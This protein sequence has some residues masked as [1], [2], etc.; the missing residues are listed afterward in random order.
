MEADDDFFAQMAMDEAENEDQEPEEED[1]WDPP[2]API[3]STSRVVEPLPVVE[4]DGVGK[5]RGE[6][7]MG[8]REGKRRLMLE[9]EE[10]FGHEEEDVEMGGEYAAARWEGRQLMAATTDPVLNQ[11]QATA[12]VPPQAAGRSYT[13]RFGNLSSVNLTLKPGYVEAAPIAATTFDGRTFIIK[14]RKR[15]D[16]FEES[17]DE[18]VRSVWVLE[19]ET[20]ADGQRRR[21]TRR[22]CPSSV[23][24]CSRCRTTTW[25]TRSRR[26]QRSRRSRTRR[27]RESSRQSLSLLVLTTDL[28]TVRMQHSLTILRSDWTARSGRIDIGQRSSPTC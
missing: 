2:S 11:R 23:T 4:V 7:G 6:N 9:P 8:V 3:A 5:D 13:S 1:P 25:S 18:V 20:R 26:M 24:R 19:G 14:R 17:A 22:R 16:G 10:G 27:T 28:R 15:V 21:R 12:V